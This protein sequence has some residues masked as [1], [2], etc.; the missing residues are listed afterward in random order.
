MY[1]IGHVADASMAPEMQPAARVSLTSFGIA[2]MRRSSGHVVASSKL[3]ERAECC[4]PK[5]APTKRCKQMA[6]LSKLDEPP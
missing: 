6:C 2:L 1:S 5:S 4:E 3:A